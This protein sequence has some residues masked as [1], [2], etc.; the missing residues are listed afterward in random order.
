[1]KS[2]EAMKTKLS[3]QHAPCARGL[4]PRTAARRALARAEAPEAAAPSLK[5]R[6]ILVPT[7]FSEAS[8]K[9]F[10]YAVPFA[11]RFGATICL[12]HVVEPASF[13]SDLPNVVLAKSEKE[14]A[15]D[16]RQEL[17]SIAQNEIEE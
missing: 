16:A 15:E 8:F 17:V 5:L 11:E 13:V 4:K 3:V 2:T 7:D 14:Q 12:A 9:A 6:R 1:M 10:Q